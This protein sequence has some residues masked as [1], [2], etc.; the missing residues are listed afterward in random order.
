MVEP[1][2]E[3]EKERRSMEWKGAGGKLQNYYLRKAPAV[4]PAKRRKAGRVVTD[5]KHGRQPRWALGP[6]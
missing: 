2:G 1:E 5:S 4:P 6:A 3:R